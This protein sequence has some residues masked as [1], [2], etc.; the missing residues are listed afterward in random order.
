MENREINQE[1][2]YYEIL[3]SL[4][5]IEKNVFRAVFNYTTQRIE[6]ETKCYSKENFQKIS[7]QLLFQMLMTEVERRSSDRMLEIAK[8][9]HKWGIF[10]N[11]SKEQK[12][13]L[14]SSNRWCYPYRLKL[15][16]KLFRKWSAW[17]VAHSS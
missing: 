16:K 10:N 12:D 17:E 6:E 2:N 9:F 8:I 7:P 15:A 11:L 13:L 4:S 3:D 5:G 14:L 1:A